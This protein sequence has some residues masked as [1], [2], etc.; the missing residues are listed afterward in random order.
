MEVGAKLFILLGISES[1]VLTVA[2]WVV[3][4]SM[5]DTVGQRMERIEPSPAFMVWSP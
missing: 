3:I 5:P 1:W 2:S 4:T